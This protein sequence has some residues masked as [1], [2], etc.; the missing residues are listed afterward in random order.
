MCVCVCVCAYFFIL[1]YASSSIDNWSTWYY[2]MYLSLY[3]YI[4]MYVCVC[5]C[6]TYINETYHNF[7]FSIHALFTRVLE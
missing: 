1:Y 3:I 4:Y 7:V 6:V 2:S 5:V